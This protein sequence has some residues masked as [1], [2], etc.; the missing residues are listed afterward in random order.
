MRMEDSILK[1]MAYSFAILT[2]Y[3]LSRVV[4]SIWWRPKSLEKQL[5]RQGIRGTRY[6]LLFGDA[7][8]MKQSFMEAR[9]KPMAL[10]HSIVPRVV[11]FYHEIAQKYGKPIIILL[12]V[13]CLFLCGSDDLELE[14]QGKFQLPGNPLGYLLSR[15]LSYLQGEKWA[16]R[17]KLLT[18]AFHFEKL[19]KRTSGYEV[20]MGCKKQGMV[21]AFSVSCRKLIERWKNLVAPQGTYELDMMHE[22]Q[23]LTGDV[24]SQVAFGSN[25]EEGKKVFELQKEQAV[26]VM[27]AFR[28]F[29]IPGFRFVPIGKNKKRYYIDSEI[30]AILKKII[31]KRKQTMKPGDLGNDDLLG[32]LL[33]C[34]E[35]T[36]SEMT[37]EDVIEECK[38][39][40]FAGQ[41]TTANWLTWTILL[42][43]MHPNWQ[44]KAREEVLQLCG[45]KM[46]DIE[47]IN[48]LK[49]V[50]MILHE[51]LRLYPPVTQQFRHTCERINIAG[52][53]IPAGVNL[54]LPTL[55]LHHSPEYWGDDVEEFKPER[56]SEGVSKASKG[57]QIAFYP[58]GWGHRICLGQGFAMIEAKM[59]LAM[60]LQH[61]W[62]ELSPTYTH[63][64]HT[65]ITLQ[66]QHGAPIILHEI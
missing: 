52:M 34:Q 4:Y 25:Y 10:N 12:L 14:K 11:P 58:F 6:K 18:P 63:A 57:D 33:Q 65:V 37:I 1:T 38:L 60:I 44:E 30:K 61:F 46:P 56:F 55:L 9:S 43:S 42:L 16:K 3:T 15:G 26:L 28:T 47:A 45:K 49:I 50:S 51:V 35:Q 36:D 29:Y 5:R 23:N 13:Y 2:M 59:A 21:P 40:Y 19:K 39:F 27:E 8:A 17:R 66:P 31:L 20:L 62:F 64:P 48:R 41:E 24:I 54:V 22:F 32:L 53:C 7:K